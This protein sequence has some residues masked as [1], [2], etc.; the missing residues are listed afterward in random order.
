MAMGAGVPEQMPRL[1]TDLAHGRT[2]EYLAKIVGA[3]QVRGGRVARDYAM[4]FDPARYTDNRPR[5]LDPMD[6]L[7]IAT[8]ADQVQAFMH[9][10]S[11]D[12]MPYGYVMEN[13]Y[14]GGHNAPPIG[15]KPLIGALPSRSTP[16]ATSSIL[17][18]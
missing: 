2:V 5:E 1:L 13:H 7:L 8:T 18:P 17:M 16:S 3:K 11:D 12:E 15:G 14:A 9:G 4:P 10:R 6:F